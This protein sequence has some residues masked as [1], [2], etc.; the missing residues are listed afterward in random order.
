MSAD[1]KFGAAGLL[2]SPALLVNINAKFAKHP[3]AQIVFVASV[4]E[5]RLSFPVH[6]VVVS[7]GDGNAF[8]SFEDALLQ[9][10]HQLLLSSV[11]LPL[12][13][14]VLL[15]ELFDLRARLLNG[16]LLSFSLL[17]G[18][19]QLSGLKLLFELLHLLPPLLNLF[20][21][22]LLKFVELLLNRGVFGHLVQH[23]LGVHIT[24]L[25]LSNGRR[26]KPDP[27][28]HPRKHDS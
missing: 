24:N 26:R 6:H 23:I 3:V 17:I 10:T 9:G 22:L 15:S 25:L 7:V 20:S 16:L 14:E 5:K 1:E 2:L 28:D 27:D 21:P 12:R 18:I 8:S 4:Q 19:Q 11:Q 13:P